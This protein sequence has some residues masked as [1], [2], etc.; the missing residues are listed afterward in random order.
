MLTA[1]VRDYLKCLKHIEDQSIIYLTIKQFVFSLAF[2]LIS[3]F[4][5]ANTNTVVTPKSETMRVAS[6][7]LVTYEIDNPIMGKLSISVPENALNNNAVCGFTVSFNDGGSGSWGGSGSF[8]F[9]CCGGATMGDI[10]NAIIAL[11]F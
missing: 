11:F 7:K 5:F 10:L 2:M 4:A 9:N 8:W 3:S 6:E 1:E